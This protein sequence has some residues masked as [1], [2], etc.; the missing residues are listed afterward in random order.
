MNGKRIVSA[1]L[2]WL[3]AAA[4]LG[5]QEQQPSSDPMAEAF[6]PPE[7][8]MQNQQAIGLRP[9][10]GEAVQA[11]LQQV[12]TKITNVQWQLAKEMETLGSLI[13]QERVNEE[14]VLAQL[15]T[16]L[17]LEREIK[18]AQ[19]SLL[20][21]I[22]NMLTPQQQAQLQEL[23]RQGGPNPAVAALLQGKMQ[24][25]QAKAQEW[26]RTG[27]DLSP[28]AAIM[29]GFDPSVKAGKFAEAEAILDRALALLSQE[30]TVKESSHSAAEPA[31]GAR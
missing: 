19:F 2:V 14:Q 24:K 29:Q 20:I 10:Q 18:R 15:D 16:V 30:P 1:C 9:E 3:A 12:K 11:M 26:Q 6:F 28:V 17:P 7:L 4:P 31:G 8:I 21:G 22:K 25:V 23:R 5:A 27:R 13:K